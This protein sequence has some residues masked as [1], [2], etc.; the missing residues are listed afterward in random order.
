MAG[1]PD[2]SGKDMQTKADKDAFY[3]K[4]LQAATQRLEAA[5]KSGNEQQIKRC[6]EIVRNLTDGRGRL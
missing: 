6:E 1:K 4:Q 3:K 2:M 5:R